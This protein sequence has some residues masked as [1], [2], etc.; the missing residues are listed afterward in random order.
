MDPMEEATLAAVD[1]PAVSAE[2]D[3][4]QARTRALRSEYNTF[5]TAA[6]RARDQLHSCL[7]EVRR[8][9]TR[10]QHPPHPVCVRHW[11]PHIAASFINL[12]V[13]CDRLCVSSSPERPHPIPQPVPQHGLPP[14]PPPPCLSRRLSC[15]SP[16]A[17]SMAP[18][19]IGGSTSRSTGRSGQQN[20]ATRRN[21]RREERATVRGPVKKQPP[22]GLSHGGACCAG[23]G[24][25]VWRHPNLCA[26]RS[27]IIRLCHALPRRA[28]TRIC[29][30]WT[31]WWRRLI[32]ACSALMRHATQHR[33][34]RQ[35]CGP[36]P[37]ASRP[38]KGWSPPR[39]SRARARYDRDWNASSSGRPPPWTPRRR[40]LVW[41]A[42]RPAWPIWRQC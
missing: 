3:E 20:A 1:A 8:P 2:F 13:G 14:I 23:G 26:P 34:S 9:R 42:S 25:S 6:S 24:S 7:T 38:C 12:L 29:R 30:S 4:F 21:M 17:T 16:W 41:S 36:E 10:A 37:R 11:N 39:S 22:D 32:C 31:S 28:P 33:A 35:C 27:C 40:E 18:D 19:S 5:D 15:L